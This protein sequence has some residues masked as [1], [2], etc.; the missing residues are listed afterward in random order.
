MP[1]KKA[2]HSFSIAS[3]GVYLSVFLPLVCRVQRRKCTENWGALLH[4]CLIISQISAFTQ[5]TLPFGSRADTNLCSLQSHL[6]CS[7]CRLN[8]FP[9]QTKARCQWTLVCFLTS[10]KGALSYPSIMS[11][12]ISYWFNLHRDHRSYLSVWPPKSYFFKITFFVQS[13]IK[14]FVLILNHEQTAAVNSCFK[15][16]VNTGSS[17]SNVSYVS[18]CT[19]LCSPVNWPITFAIMTTSD[20]TNVRCA[21]RH[22]SMWETCRSTSSYTQVRTQC[23]PYYVASGRS[24]D[25]HS[26][27]LLLHTSWVF[28]FFLSGFLRGETFPVWQMRQRV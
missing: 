4:F 15:Y 26:P 19:G 17:M 7:K 8:P 18:L 14:S 27:L 2:I 28:C 16:N 21:T 13:C 6:T 11:G 22:L 5:V 24:T 9:L 23:V 20:H 12:N 25:R 3:R 1:A 10:W